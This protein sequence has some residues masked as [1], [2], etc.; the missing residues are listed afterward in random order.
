MVLEIE[1]SIKANGS[2][3]RPSQSFIFLAC[4]RKYHRK[5][6]APP[7]GDKRVRRTGTPK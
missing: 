2:E 4:V 5:F 3:A 1:A 7:K 6:W